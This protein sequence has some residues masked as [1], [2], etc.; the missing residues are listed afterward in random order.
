MGDPHPAEAVRFAGVRASFRSLGVR[1]YRL[2]FAGQTV[3][4]AGVWVQFVAQA[5]LVLELTDSGAWLGLVAAMQFLPILVVGPWA[6]LLCDRVDKRR[7][8]IVTQTLMMFAAFVLGALVLADRASFPVVFLLATLT[9]TAY[10]FDQPARRT[11]VTELVDADSEANAIALNG[12]IGNSAKI[13]GPALAG[14]L[15]EAIGSGW[16]F[17]VNGLSSIAVLTALVR[18]DPAEIRRAPVIERARGQIRDGFGYAWR[19]PT[20]RGPLLV[21]SAVAIM[22][23]NWNVLVPMLVTRDLEGSAGTFGVVMAVMSL[24]SVSGT[25]FLARRPE[26][27]LRFLGTWVTLYAVFLLLMAL[28]PTVLTVSL[29]GYAVGAGSMVLFNATIVGLQLGSSPEMRGRVMAMFSM[30]FFGSYALGGP[31]SGWVAE[32]YGARVA[33]GGGAVASLAIGVA[34]MAVTRGSGAPA[35]GIGNEVGAPAAAVLDAA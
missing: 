22:A 8:L 3:S 2:W 13:V 1:N 11:I 18:M 20:I 15:V 4:Q 28:A 26:S 14:V 33:L 9:G 23:F 7:L 30:V 5:L 19:Q 17:A 31:L 24:G 27:G 32:R 21:L 34:V 12:L 6:G 10:A 25:L 16:C 29:A 35:G